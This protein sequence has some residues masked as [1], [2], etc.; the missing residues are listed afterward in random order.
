M[1]KDY[2]KIYEEHHGP[3]PKDK[4]GRSYDIHH[5]DGDRT[6]NHPTNLKAVTVQEHYDIHYSQGDYGA[7][8][9]IALQRMDATEKDLTEINR[10]SALKRV[11][12]GTHHWLGGA[13]QKKTQRR[14]VLNGTHNLLGSKHALDRLA[15][16]TH[17]SQNKKTCEHCGKTTGSGQ[18]VQWHGNNCKLKPIN[19]KC[20]IF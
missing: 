15:K 8:Y 12:N 1:N 19:N 13:I 9:L 14:R 17:P 4:N 20:V 3:I 5:I 6:N 10:K 18:Y 16:G 7:C 2:R 11:E